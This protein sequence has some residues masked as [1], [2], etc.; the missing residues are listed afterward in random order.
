LGKR[1]RAGLN[2]GTL[3]VGISLILSIQGRTSSNR[4][5]LFDPGLHQSILEKHSRY[6]R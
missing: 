4:K 1:E 5:A 6:R 3:H 2:V